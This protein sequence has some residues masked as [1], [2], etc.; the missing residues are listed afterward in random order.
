MPYKKNGSQPC[1]Y[2]TFSLYPGTEA[3]MNLMRERYERRE[4]LFDDDDP[5]LPGGSLAGNPEVEEFLRDFSKHLAE[6]ALK[7]LH[8]K[9]TPKVFRGRNLCNTCWVKKDIRLLYP[10]GKSDGGKGVARHKRKK[11][12]S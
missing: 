4:P 10:P 6:F 3:K 12:S 8:C 7:C 2:P 9:K 1:R 5:I 11:K